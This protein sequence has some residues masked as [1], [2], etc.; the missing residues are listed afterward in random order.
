MV[1]FYQMV[2]SGDLEND[3]W[4][5]EAAQASFI[6]QVL[7][8]SDDSSYCSCPSY[9]GGLGVRF[10]TDIEDIPDGAVIESVSLFM[11][12]RT[13]NGSGHRS[14]TVN[15][16]S[17]DHKSRYLTRHLGA[18][19][20]W[21]THEVGTFT[22]DPIGQP[23]DVERINKLQVRVFST[24][25]IFNSI[26]FSLLYLR[27]NYHKQPSV[28]I[29]S[30]TGTIYTPSP[31][32]SWDYLP[33]QGEPQAR[34]EYRI[35]LASEVA[36]PSFNP[37]HAAAVV[38]GDVDGEQNSVTLSTSLNPDDYYVYVRAFSTFECRSA[39]DNNAFTVQGPAPGVPGDDNAGV[40]GTPGIGV[41]T[42]VPDS[43]TSSAVISMRD[44]SNLLSVQQAD[45]EIPADPIEW[46]G[47][48]ATV[49]RDTGS[50]FG[51]GVASLSIIAAAAGNAKATTT[52]IELSGALPVTARAQIKAAATARPVNL[53][54]DFYDETFTAL[55]GSLTTQITDAT[56]TWT[57]AVLQ[58]STPVDAVY[59][60]VSAEVVGAA[61]SEQHN[62]DHI[63]LMYGSGTSWSDGG[64][65]SRNML[66]SFLA[67]GD[68]PT[69]SSGESW[70]PA[71]VATTTDRVAVSGIGSHGRL[72]NRMTYVG[73]TGTIAYRA[74][75]AVWTSPTTG[76]DYTLNKP[77][78]I[79]DNDLLIA[80]VTSTESGTIVPPSG[81][82]AVNTA[83]LDDGDTNI[84]L[85]ILKRSGLAADPA[86]WMG[87][88]GEDSS[89]RTAVVVAYSG[90]AHSDFQFLTESVSTL[91]GG[92]LVPQTATVEN[93]D[94]NAWRISAFAVSD[95]AAGAAMTANI[96]P[97]ESSSDIHYVGPSTRWSQ[98]SRSTDYRIMKPDGVEQGD[99]LLAS[100]GISGDI[101]SLTPPDGWT[102][103]RRIYQNYD[104][105]DYS[106]DDETAHSGDITVFMLKKTAGADEP[107]SWTGTHTDWGQPKLTQ[108][109]AYRNADDAANQFVD[110]TTNTNQD[111]YSVGTGTAHNTDSSAWRVCMF[112]ACTPQSDSF[113]DSTESRQRN[114][115]STSRYGFPDIVISWWDSNG[116]VSTGD[117]SRSAELYGYESFTMAAW[118][119]FIKPAPANP[120]PGPDETERVDN[121][122]GSANPWL[123]T[124][125]Y[126]SN[127]AADVGDQSVYGTIVPGS[128]TSVDSVATW[129]GLIK[130]AT[131][132]EAGLA[133]AHTSNM[134]DIS[135]VPDGVLALA[136]RR[137]T[138]MANF[139]GST[140]GTPMLRVQFY[141]AN[142][143][144]EEDVAQGDT[145]NDTVWTRSHAEFDIPD[146]TTGIRPVLGATS[147]QIADTVMFDRIGLLLGAVAQYGE[148]PVWRNGTARHEHPIWSKPVLEASDDA[149]EGYGAWSALFAQSLNPPRYH[150]DDAALL[151]VD[152][153]IVPL[154]NRRY[155]A[156]TISYGLE[157]DTF[158]SGF[159]PA[160]DEASFTA[161]NW[162]L[163][164]LTDPSLNMK[165]LPLA[166]PTAVGTMNT[167]ASFQPLG[168][169]YPIVITEGYKSDSLELTL[170]MYRE[171]YAALKSLI[172]NGRTLLL[173]SDID[174]SWWVR[175]IDDLDVEI[176]VTAKR[177]ENPL[178]FVKVKFVQVAPEE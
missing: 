47:T 41:P 158:A 176:Q 174:E 84:S 143:L 128:G 2:P 59:A 152:H 29:T 72:C 91:S 129:I 159:G 27:I 90:A 114:D 32:I 102:Q 9:R 113:Y 33:D 136:G 142:Q 104:G 124:A 112:A 89:R 101:T 70:T 52:M 80:F 45:L 173:Q 105:S 49:A 31:T 83:S 43:Y 99:L 28:K 130:P 117:H 160:S 161:R 145:F 126:D 65:A 44:T 17:K 8:D 164:D 95:N 46:L 153:T 61:L 21:V 163:K 175:T 75:S 63:G 110:D 68:D 151:Y 121:D 135:S 155:R 132:I 94:P 167:A 3:G 20:D 24:N 171:E 133:Q 5:I 81:W 96:D 66:T 98:E 141:R 169:D 157:G 87:N 23:W 48:N 122:N 103:F 26:D 127:G 111:R 148:T 79:A 78:G 4:T 138:L 25:N 76:S 71:N 172:K 55:D 1:Y 137:V 108:C 19:S 37:N 14:V 74:T 106:S 57:E 22:R 11:R 154:H 39:W 58:G 119:G 12:I 86:T 156:Q 51:D 56:G 123:S 15:L 107:S 166:K 150:F 69:P 92:G 6:W 149:G 100:V 120:A 34:A 18:T 146:G 118:M 60:T 97:P 165:I 131:N 125:V 144:L 109:V 162:W 10:P 85:F 67:T 50:H 54:V 140:A 116:S 13:V 170:K 64:H 178:R 93:T 134:V 7:S 73:A 62:I 30:P 147:L 139:L 38:K 177:T 53:T 36:K 82:T 77:A 115:N 40:A 88:L 168:S 42:V 35:F 16:R